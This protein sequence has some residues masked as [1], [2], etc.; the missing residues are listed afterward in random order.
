MRYDIRFTDEA[1]EWLADRGVAP[2]SEDT[3][4]DDGPR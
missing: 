2:G 4:G 3:H 1:A